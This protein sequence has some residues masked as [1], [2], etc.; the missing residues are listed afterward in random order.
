MITL[1]KKAPWDWEEL[2][3][4]LERLENPPTIRE[5]V[6]NKQH[7][8]THTKKDVSVSRDDASLTR[9][10]EEAQALKVSLAKLDEADRRQLLAD[11]APIIQGYID[12]QLSMTIEAAVS[13]ALV[14]IRQDL[15]RSTSLITVEAIKRAIDQV[16]L[17]RYEKS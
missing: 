16:D 9:Y 4:M 14:R 8:Y 2:L 15:S 5:G 13:N 3:P 12:E 6:P 11:L 17:S 10:L 7:D 1:M